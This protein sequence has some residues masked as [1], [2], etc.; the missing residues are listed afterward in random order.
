[1]NKQ[2]VNMNTLR[3]MVAN[4]ALTPNGNMPPM[5]G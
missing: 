3:R 2:S 5:E 1:M 4:L